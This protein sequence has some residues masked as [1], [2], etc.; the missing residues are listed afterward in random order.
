MTRAREFRVGTP[1]GSV[2]VEETPGDDPAIVMMHGFPDDHRIYDK[3]VPPLSPK[4]A[5]VLDWLGYGRSDRPG[6]AR[7]GSE[8]HAAQ[9]GAVLDRLDIATAVL[10][11]HDA[12][13]PDA[14][15][16]AVGHPDRVAALTLLNTYF[17]HQPSLQFPEMIRLL[18]DPNFKPLADAMVDDENQRL[19]LLLQT[20]A[21]LG[22]APEE[23][24]GV[25]VKAVLPQFFG[26]PD[27]PDALAAI[28]SWTAALFGSLDSQDAMIAA[29]ALS[30]LQMPVTLIFGGRDRCLSA[31]LGA[32][33]SSLFRT[34]S[35]HVLDDASHWPQWDE[36]HA[37]AQLILTQPQPADRA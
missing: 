4:R 33:L 35:I 15:A 36:P 29:G 2:Y 25:G 5:V 24:E 18:A 1:Q 6:D 13:G 27:Q 30:D 22:L 37:V 7:F 12:A 31:D 16:Y 9:L 10:V 19:W 28:R 32:E 8:D 26:D 34:S 20:A 17:G 23:T 14:V 21:R 11:A 3:L